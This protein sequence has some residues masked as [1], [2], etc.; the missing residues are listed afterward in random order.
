MKIEYTSERDGD[1][2][3]GKGEDQIIVG[4]GDWIVKDERADSAFSV[5]SPHTFELRYGPI[6]EPTTEEALKSQQQRQAIID[7]TETMPHT[8]E[9]LLIWRRAVMTRAV[10][11][12]LSPGV[13]LCDW[14]EELASAKASG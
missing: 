12:G 5:L 11:A 14:F 1:L 7:G 3:L 9:G 6:P 10:A 13:G 4:P 8:L 2:A